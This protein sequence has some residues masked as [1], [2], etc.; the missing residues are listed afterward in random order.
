M[1]KQKNEER[2]MIPENHQSSS[3]IVSQKRKA[4]RESVILNRAAGP[5][6][7]RVAYL[8]RAMPDFIADE[9]HEIGSWLTARLVEE[10]DAHHPP[11]EGMKNFLEQSAGAHDL[12][13]AD[14]LVES[15][16]EIAYFR[17]KAGVVRGSANQAADA[18]NR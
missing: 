15:I 8:R 1:S 4:W 10:I 6:R 3:A 18:T 9:L 16:I 13:L 2:I 14:D 7:N 11:I 17:W 5:V 12:P